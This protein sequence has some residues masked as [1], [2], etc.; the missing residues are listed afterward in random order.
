MRFEASTGFGR[1][2]IPGVGGGDIVVTLLPHGMFTRIC[3]S[4]PISSETVVAHCRSKKRA[5]AKRSWMKTAN[6]WF[7]DKGKNGSE[8]TG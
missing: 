3:D 1:G 4:T 5:T 6:L 7:V 8:N 2:V